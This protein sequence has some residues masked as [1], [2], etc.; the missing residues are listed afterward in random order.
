MIIRKATIDDLEKI[1]AVE[2]ECFPSAEAATKDSFR[3]RLLHYP[4]HFILMLDGD[5]IVAFVNGMVTD[6]PDL[7]DEMYDN[8]DLHNENGE[9]QMIFGVDTVP[10]YR[11][12]GYAGE[13]I[14]QFIDE[15]H[16]QNRK[17]LVLTCKEHLLRYYSKFGFVSEGITDKSVHG[18]VVWYQMR[19]TF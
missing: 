15:A 19:L 14:K 13:L 5:R 1:V 8:A 7:T 16:S 6:K 9:W 18:G 4:S 10:E 2:A 12:H 3:E 11:N 17:G